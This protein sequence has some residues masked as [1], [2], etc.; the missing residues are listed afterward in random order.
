MLLIENDFGDLPQ[1]KKG[2][3]LMTN[4][5]FSNGIG[6]MFAPQ[7]GGVELEPKS[8][9]FSLEKE[10]TFRLEGLTVNIDANGDIWGARYDTGEALRHNSKYTMAKGLNSTLWL[11][12]KK[13]MW[14]PLD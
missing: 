14:H 3:L 12:D 9:S 7:N 11:G 5:S 13:G 1:V 4:S 8:Y 2:Q 6:H 10:A